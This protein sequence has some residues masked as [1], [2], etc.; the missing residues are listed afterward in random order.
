M[1]A[2]LHISFPIEL[3]ETNVALQLHWLLPRSS[4]T[5]V[6]TP[7]AAILRGLK[8]A[9]RGKDF[10]FQILQDLDHVIVD[11]FNLFS[12]HF[13]STILMK[14]IMDSREFQPIS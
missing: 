2:A 8:L 13:C 5:R 6:A 11:S 12:Y 10:K 4:A 7:T 3:V 14:I 9:H 1:L